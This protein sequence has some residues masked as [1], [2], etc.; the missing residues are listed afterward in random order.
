MS[1]DN[2]YSHAFHRIDVHTLSDL[3]DLLKCFDPSSLA[4]KEQ[5]MYR[6]FTDELSLETEVHDS[7]TQLIL[8]R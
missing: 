8:G 4:S 3:K 2:P 6:N 5:E 1:K 7:V